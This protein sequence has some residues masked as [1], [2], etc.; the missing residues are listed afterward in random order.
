REKN[1]ND[2]QIN[3][4]NDELSKFEKKKERIIDLIV[5]GYISKEEGNKRQNKID[6]DNQDKID[7]LK[8]IKKRQK[9]IDRQIQILEN[10]KDN[11]II[12]LNKL[13]IF[14][15]DYIKKIKIEKSN[16]LKDLNLIYTRSNELTYRI[17]I[18]NIIDKVIIL[19]TG[20]YT[21]Y[22][23]KEDDN[24]LGFKQINYGGDTAD[25]DFK[26]IDDKIYTIKKINYMVLT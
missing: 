18:T 14:A 8:N 21:K 12:D 11:N 7:N 2:I 16:K 15:N 22:L 4:I 23:I 20:N 5:D 26:F 10:D 13:K 1:N 3:I 25:L 17:E 19:Y 9:E 24:N 6:K